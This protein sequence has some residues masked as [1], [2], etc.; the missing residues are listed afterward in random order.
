MPPLYF[1][2]CLY[3]YIVEYVSEQNG[4][5]VA[6]TFFNILGMLDNVSLLSPNHGIAII[7]RCLLTPRSMQS[8]DTVD[9]LVC[10]QS[11]I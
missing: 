2:L 11:N 4:M 3:M 5:Q 8:E 6:Q 7:L 10:S 9:S 1:L